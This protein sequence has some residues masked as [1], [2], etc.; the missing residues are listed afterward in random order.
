MRAQKTLRKGN[1]ALLLA[2]GCT[3]APGPR[4]FSALS[5]T[6][7]PLLLL[8]PVVTDVPGRAPPP[9]SAPAL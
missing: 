1:A 2:K 9:G 6:V 8:S 3:N 5:P 7:T 4:P